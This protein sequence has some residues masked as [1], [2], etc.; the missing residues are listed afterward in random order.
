MEGHLLLLLNWSTHSYVVNNRSA[1]S[2]AQMPPALI[3]HYIFLPLRSRGRKL[4]GVCPIASLKTMWM[5]ADSVDEPSNSVLLDDL[6]TIPADDVPPKEPIT[7]G[8]A[9]DLWVYESPIERG[10][11]RVWFHLGAVVSIQP[12]CA[13]GC[14]MLGMDGVHAYSVNEPVVGVIFWTLRPSG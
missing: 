10:V 2:R 5:P 4:F 3:P 8:M 12:D 6:P 9:L 13:T 1:L 7:S 14:S 11:F